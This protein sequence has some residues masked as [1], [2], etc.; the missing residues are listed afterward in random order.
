MFGPFRSCMWPIIFR[1]SAVKNA[2]AIKMEII[3]NAGGTI[4]RESIAR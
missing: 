4:V 2:T 1:S 3:S